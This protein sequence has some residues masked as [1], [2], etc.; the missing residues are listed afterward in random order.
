[1][2][3][4]K[5]APNWWL[6]FTK[7]ILAFS[8]IFLIHI[9]FTVNPKIIFL[10]VMPALLI[11]IAFNILHLRFLHCYKAGICYTRLCT[12]RYINSEEI[13]CV[14]FSSFFLF[15]IFKVKLDNGKNFHFY[16]W[17]LDDEAQS[18]ISEM[19]CNKLADKVENISDKCNA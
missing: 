13:S 12:E 16:N 11:I 10:T 14:S 1:M 2:K 7:C 19:Y 4:I 15:T 8:I 3:S 5:L 6:Q 9:M 17:Q 18:A